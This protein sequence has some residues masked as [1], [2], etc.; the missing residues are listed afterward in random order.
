VVA[1]K[2]KLSIIGS[3]KVWYVSEFG[4]REHGRAVRR[5]GVLDGALRRRHDVLDA[6]L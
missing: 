4:R 2:L 1:F 5:E 6:L 3:P